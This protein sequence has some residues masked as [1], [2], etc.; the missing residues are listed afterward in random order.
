MSQTTVQIPEA[1]PLFVRVTAGLQAVRYRADY[2]LRLPNGQQSEW[3]LI[4]YFNGGEGDDENNT[5][6]IADSSV[7]A[8]SDV[9]VQCLIARVSDGTRPYN[10]TVQL[11]HNDAGQVGILEFEGQVDQDAIPLV[12]WFNLESGQ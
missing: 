2:R 1:G 3:I 9:C 5:W 12:A 11:L 7:L 4:D 8:G 6:P 10:I